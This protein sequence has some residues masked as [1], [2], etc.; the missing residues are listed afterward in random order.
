M[1]QKLFIIIMQKTQDSDQDN[2]K[3]KNDKNIKE[4]YQVDFSKN[5]KHVN[6]TTKFNN[7]TLQTL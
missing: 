6:S 4:I 1:I 5:H 3:K 7:I 2:R